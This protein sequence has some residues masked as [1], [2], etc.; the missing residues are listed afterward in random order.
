MPT[1][2]TTQLEAVNRML[3]AA[4]EAVV[5]SLGTSDSA[6]AEQILDDVERDVQS[7]GWHWNTRTRTFTVAAGE[8][9]IADD[10]VS[11]SFANKKL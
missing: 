10:V 6:Q 9:A 3:T 7:H 1:T 11:N 5:A 4:G 8:I 2:K